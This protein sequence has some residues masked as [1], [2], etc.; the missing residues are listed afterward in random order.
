MLTKEQIQQVQNGEIKTLYHKE[1]GEGSVEL[2]RVDKLNDNRIKA[3]IVF[4]VPDLLEDVLKPEFLF[5]DIPEL[6]VEPWE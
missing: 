1:L 6:S 3:E 4:K 2:A 5:L